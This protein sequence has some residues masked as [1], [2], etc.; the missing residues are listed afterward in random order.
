MHPR[1]PSEERQH[2]CHPGWP[3][4]MDKEASIKSICRYGRHIGGRHTVLREQQAL[5]ASCSQDLQGRSLHRQV[6]R[7]VIRFVIS[8]SYRSWAGAAGV[9]RL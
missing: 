7:V 3:T 6:P 5:G 1:L 8:R 4:K 9:C 2:F